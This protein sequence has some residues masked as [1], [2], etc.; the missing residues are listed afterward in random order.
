MWFLSP[1]WYYLTVKFSKK[2]TLPFKKELRK[3]NNISLSVFSGVLC[4]FSANEIYNQTDELSLE[5]FVCKRYDSTPSLYIIMLC[6]YLSKYWEWLDTYFIVHSDKKVTNLHYFH[7]MSTPS[8]AYVNTFYKGVTPSYIYACFLNT[9][10]HTFMYWYYAFPD[11]K[12]RRYKKV[13]TKV[14]IFQHVYMLF[15]VFYIYINCFDE[16]IFLAVYMTLVCY[17]YYFTMFVKFYLNTYENKSLS[18]RE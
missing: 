3:I 12:L 5:P 9:F 13:I 2:I 15:S 8:L 1:V 6:F 14:Q 4:A 7:H 16:K 18:D 10:V 17:F 11:S